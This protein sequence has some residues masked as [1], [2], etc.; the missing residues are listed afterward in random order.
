MVLGYFVRGVPAFQCAVK[1]LQVISAKRDLSTDRKDSDQY[2]AASANQ[3]VTGAAGE[4]SRRACHHR[5]AVAGAASDG[6]ALK[7]CRSMLANAVRKR[8]SSSNKP[9]RKG[10][11]R[12]AP[13]G[14]IFIDE[15][16]ATTQ[17]TRDCARYLPR[18]T[19]LGGVGCFQVR[20]ED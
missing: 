5:T 20:P 14:L 1:I 13:Q 6:S 4:S 2:E 10:T 7:K 15:S 16:G 9:S 12:I 3:G 18:R 8:I 11:G 17:M 19:R